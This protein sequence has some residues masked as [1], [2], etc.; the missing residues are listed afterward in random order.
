MRSFVQLKN[1]A[2]SSLVLGIEAGTLE[3]QV[4]ASDADRFPALSYPG[5]CFFACLVSDAGNHEYVRATARD[6]NR[7]TVERGQEG[8]TAQAFPAGTRFEL[9]VT[10]RAWEML[11][12]NRWQRPT[13]AAGNV[14]LPT[15]VDAVSFTLPGDLTALFQANRAVHLFQSV[16]QYGFVL[17]S[18]YA[19]GVTTVTVQNC[20]VDMGLSYVEV[21]MDAL[22]APKYGE[23][24]RADTADHATYA[25]DAGL[26]VG[27][28]IAEVRSGL[29]QDGHGHALGEISGAGSAAALNVGT[30]AGNL[31]Q[32]GEDRKLPAGVLPG[33]TRII[34]EFITSTQDWTVPAGVTEVRVWVVG[35]GAGGE[36]I[37]NAGGSR[38]EGG[39][40]GGGCAYKMVSA[41][42][43][44]QTIPCTIGAGSA[45]SSG[46]GNLATDGGTSSFGS[47]CSATGG[48]GYYSSSVGGN[49]VGGDINYSGG[50]GPRDDVTLASGHGGRAGGPWGGTGGNQRVSVGD[51]YAG[52]FGG[53]GGGASSST[54][55]TK[56]GGA[57]GAGLIVIEYNA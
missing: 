30:D 31:V 21:G 6:G 17:A 54:S 34:R 47:H 40:G 22:A 27:Q 41:L 48:S 33:G 35:G 23:S 15:R 20:S 5:D 28:T 3:I 11:A 16:E 26:L 4:Q 32:L 49:G 43:P 10:A 52:Q 14:L 42:T 55:S 12:E 13:D 50:G 57:G 39:G 53:G 51:G 1:L 18:V 19:S 9:R 46:G 36:G 29:S 2:G 45:G 8:T 37:Y 25:D 44:G 7:I 24:S 56:Y 38:G